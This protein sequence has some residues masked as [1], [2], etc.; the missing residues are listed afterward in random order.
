MRHA[1]PCYAT[2][3]SAYILSN[4]TVEDEAQLAD[5]VKNAPAT[6]ARYGGR[7]LVRRGKVDRLEG[8]W[9]PGAL[10]VLEFPT[11]AQAKAWYDSPEYT[12]LR[13]SS[14]RGAH[15]DLFLVDGI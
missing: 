8:E 1:R 7:Y 11:R 4:L 5:Y 10:I 15:R 3:M 13:K 9:T 14:F 12:E 2:G 6:I